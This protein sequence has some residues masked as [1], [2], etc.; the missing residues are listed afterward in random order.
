MKVGVALGGGGVR[1]LAHVLA[2]EAIDVC[3]IRPTMIAGTSMGAIIGAVY[4][5]GRSGQEIREDI[6]QRFITENFKDIYRKKGDL[7]KWLSTVRL[8][9]GRNGLLRADGFLQYLLEE[10]QVDTFEE[11]Q[12][13][14]RVVA[15]DFHSGQ[16]F[17]FQSGELRPAMLSSMSIPGIFVP[18]THE[19]H[20]LVDGGVVNNLP[21]DL[22]EPECDVTVAIDVIPPR[23]PALQDEREPNLI[24]ITLGVFDILVQ[25]VTD[26]KLEKHP[27]TIYIR[28]N[29]SGN[30]MLDFEK[31]GTVF[32]Q[33]APAMDVL[34]EKLTNLLESKA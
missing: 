22:L 14:L 34:R 10:I 19:G 4:A 26:A 20:M 12:V 29:L 24:D 16:P 5:S 13:P 6:Q 23:A 31:A 7:I 32:D 11:L 8:S 17:L 1:G 33:A 21:Y 27:P 2:L 3:G 25:R 28:P 18:V 30:R 9:W 15:T